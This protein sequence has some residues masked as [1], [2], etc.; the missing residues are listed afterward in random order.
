MAHHRCTRCKRESYP[1][2]KYAQ[3]LFCEPCL[4]E[5]R[6][7]IVPRRGFWSIFHDFWNEIVRV[8]NSIFNRKT[9]R[10]EFKL[11]TSR[12]ITKFKAV[13]AKARVIPVDPVTLTPQKR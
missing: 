9:K 13:Q 5:L 8:A 1:R 11:A 3:G 10:V 2:H 7:E 4:R 12:N 6:Y